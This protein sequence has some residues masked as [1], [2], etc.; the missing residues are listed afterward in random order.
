MITDSL[1]LSGSARNGAKKKARNLRRKNPFSKSHPEASASLAKNHEVTNKPLQLN[2]TTVILLLSNRFHQLQRSN[3]IVQ[4]CII[5][6]ISKIPPCFRIERQSCLCVV[7]SDHAVVSF[8]TT[9][10][11]FSSQINL[12]D[13]FCSLL[14]TTRYFALFFSSFSSPVALVVAGSNIFKSLF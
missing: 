3:S 14:N 11:F 1:M 4:Q 13:P 5:I 6:P 12:L 7:S 2:P 9:V 8:L 10:S